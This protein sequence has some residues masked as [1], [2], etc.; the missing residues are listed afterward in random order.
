MNLEDIKKIF[1]ENKKLLIS[2]GL[3]PVALVTAHAVNK[4]VKKKRLSPKKTD[5]PS[6]EIASL[7][8]IMVIKEIRSNLAELEN[9]G[10]S[11]HFGRSKKQGNWGYYIQNKKKNWIFFCCSDEFET[12]IGGTPYWIELDEVSSLALKKTG[13]EEEL[14]VAVHPKIQGRVV[15]AI[16][17]DEIKDYTGVAGII[18]KVALTTL[19]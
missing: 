13:I 16:P 19:K 11:I 6:W 14:E 2:L 5:E 15:V 10:F 17:H 9:E 12:I 3:I 7:E 4:A 8:K 1:K 18:K